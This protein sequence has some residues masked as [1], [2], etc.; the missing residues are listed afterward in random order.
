MAL[1]DIPLKG[2]KYSWSTM[3]AI[4]LLQ[5]LNWFFPFLSWTNSFP[6]TMA[7]PLAMTTSDHIRCIISFQATIPKPNIFRFENIWLDMP[8]FMT[9]V[10]K[11]WTQSI[12]HADAAKRISA[13]LKHS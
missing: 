12:H 1:I 3:Q 13:M 10:Q 5:R 9:L 4:P 2:R 11:V 7:E 8:D 6:N